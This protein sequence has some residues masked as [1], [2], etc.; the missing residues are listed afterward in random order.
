[1]NGDATDKARAATPNSRLAGPMLRCLR[2]VLG[3]VITIVL[4]VAIPVF[5]WW[6][7]FPSHQNGNYI[8]RDLED[9]HAE[10]IKM[11]PADELQQIRNM[12]AEREMIGYHMSLGMDLRNDWGLW[13]GSRLSRRFNLMGIWHPDDM[14]AIILFTFWCKLHDQP[15]RLQDRVAHYHAYWKSQKKMNDTP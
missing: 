6:L 10:L 14:S 15:Y 3:V 4:L 7:P 2:I 8:P 12:K 9:A 5:A 1:M 13:K 11:L